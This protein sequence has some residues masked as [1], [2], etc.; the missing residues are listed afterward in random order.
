MFIKSRMKLTE[1]V[2]NHGHILLYFR[3]KSCFGDHSRKIKDD[4]LVIT[5]FYKN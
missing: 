1:R 4:E 3:V 2:L 5:Y